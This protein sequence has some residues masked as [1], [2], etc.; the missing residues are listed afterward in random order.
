[1]EE[2]AAVKRFVMNL[3]EEISTQVIPDRIYGIQYGEVI[4]PVHNCEN[5]HAQE[6]GKRNYD[7]ILS[8]R[9]PQILKILNQLYKYHAQFKSCNS[10]LDYNISR[11][12]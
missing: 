9:L 2:K 4:V 11:K 12:N 10:V 5:Q 3:K 6:P 1:M 7:L 8:M